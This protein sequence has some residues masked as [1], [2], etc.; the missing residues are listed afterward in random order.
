MN[1]YSKIS[2]VALVMIYASALALPVLAQQSSTDT[3]LGCKNTAAAA[4]IGSVFGALINNKDRASGAAVGAVISA[5]ACLAMDASSKQTQSSAQVLKEYQEHN[6]GN[7]PRNVTL[8]NYQGQSPASI[9]RNNGGSVE[10]VSTGALV[11]PPAQM[12]STQF[13]EELQLNIPG[14]RQPK[15][16]KKEIALEGGGGFEQSFK[17]TLDR[18]FP[19]GQ[20]TFKTRIMSSNNQVLGERSGKF[21]VI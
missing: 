21:Q 5:I 15:I 16:S 8:V 14:E 13:F 19:Q 7:T 17:F 4:A 9:G 10:L 18:T 2:A 1:K 20:Y 3:N 12:S 6:G 11:V